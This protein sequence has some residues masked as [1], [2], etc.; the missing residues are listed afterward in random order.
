MLAAEDMGGTPYDRLLV[1]A[2]DHERLCAVL[3]QYGRLA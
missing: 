3:R 2:I 1:Q